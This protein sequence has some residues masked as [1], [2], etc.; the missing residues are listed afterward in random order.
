ME[1]NMISEKQRELAK[2]FQKMHDKGK[3]FVLPNVWNAGSAVVFEKEGFKAVATTSA[4]VAYALGYPDGEDVDITDLGLIVEQITRRIDIPLSVDFERGYSENID[5]IK[6]NAMFLLN[7]GAVGFNIEDGNFDGTLDD[8]DF[9]LEKINTLVELEKELDLNFL[10]NARTCTYWLNVADDENKMKIAIERGNAFKKAGADCVFI[11]GGMDNK[12]VK[13]LVDNIDAPINII[14]N[15]KY[16]DFEGL[17][18]LGVARLS[19]GSGVVRSTFSHLIDIAENL[20]E[21]N[22]D[23]IL[24][25]EF[26][27]KKANEY[28]NQR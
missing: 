25:H 10:I 12:T 3:M 7:A 9:M 15:P 26:S 16:N 1:K 17:E 27:Y 18:K 5:E 23:M 20:Q 21:N 28:F 11:P 14:L 4:G 6:K 19:V 2:R 24:N 13:M 22:I 8:L